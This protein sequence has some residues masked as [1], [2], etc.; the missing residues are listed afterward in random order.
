VSEEFVA[1]A[2][3]RASDDRRRAA[4]EEAFYFINLD[5]S[6]LGTLIFSTMQASAMG[7]S[8][9]GVEGSNN[10]R[11]ESVKFEVVLDDEACTRRPSHPSLHESKCTSKP[12]EEELLPAV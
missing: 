11:E 6:T 8:M 10:K 7:H 4:E 12:L 2:S 5:A 3:R 9:I 1:V